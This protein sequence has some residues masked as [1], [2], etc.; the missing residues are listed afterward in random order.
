MFATEVA[1]TGLFLTIIASLV[2]LAGCALRPEWQSLASEG[3]LQSR[4]LNTGDFRHLVLANRQ[5]GDYLRVYVEGDGTP[6]IRDTRVSVDPTPSNP[7]M[8]R[9]MHHDPRP[10][11]YLGR[12]CYF[13]SA[14][15]K[16]CDRDLWTFDRYGQAVVDSMCRAANRIARERAAT[17]VELVG[18]S[19]GGAIVLGMSGCTEN[20][21]AVS[22]I[23]GNLEPNAWTEYHGYTPLDDLSPLESARERNDA[24]A[25]TH[26]QCRDDDNVPPEI[27]DAYFAKRKNAA[28]RIVADCTHA[29]G[30]ERYWSQIAGPDK[31]E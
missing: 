17:G 24:I 28:R 18:Y 19:G 7:I 27:T 29:T 1:P 2:Q 15:D 4:W 9:L 25:E 30:W 5:R 23:A 13:G 22:T 6:W 16:G 10:A 8:L 14:T 12:P 21:V 26:W 20:L 31:T 3:S 11:A